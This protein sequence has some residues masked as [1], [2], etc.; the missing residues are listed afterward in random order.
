ME[1]LPNID[2]TFPHPK[3]P[4]SCNGTELSTSTVKPRINSGVSSDG[5]RKS[6]KPVSAIVHGI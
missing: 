4:L 5:T 3:E 1:Q 6:H 2:T